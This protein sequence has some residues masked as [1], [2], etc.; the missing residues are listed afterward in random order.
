MIEPDN[1]R[2]ARDRAVVLPA[3]QRKKYVS[4]LA[5]FLKTD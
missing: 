5:K 4:I 3:I 1:L 2:F